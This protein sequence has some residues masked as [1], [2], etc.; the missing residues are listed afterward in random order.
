MPKR[1]KSRFS[2]KNLL[3]HSTEKYRKG[4]L[5]CCISENFWYRE[6]IWIKGVEGVSHSS[7]KNLVFDSTETFGRGTILCFRKILVS[8]KI[9]DKRRG[10]EVVSQFSVKNVKNFVS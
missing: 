9:M 8:K 10:R 2:T 5:M 4:T 1:G 6:S 3:S 7:V